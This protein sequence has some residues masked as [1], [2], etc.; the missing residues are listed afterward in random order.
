MDAELATLASTA[1]TTIVAALATD[2]WEKTKTAIGGLCRKTH[3]DRAAGVEADLVDTHAELLAAQA[4][5][6]TQTEQDLAADWQRKLRR[7]LTTDP[8]VADELRR[9]LDELSPTLRPGAQGW[10]G[11]V[12][13]TAKASGHAQINQLGQ[14]V[15]HITGR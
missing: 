15:Q 4:T 12:R 8:D 6:D 13:M 9:I 5:G 11:D 14:G 7:F 2:A 10:T 3:P 1:G